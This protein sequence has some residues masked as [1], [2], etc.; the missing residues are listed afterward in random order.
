MPP[1]RKAA[2][3]SRKSPTPKPSCFVIS[4]I[5]DDGSPERRRADQVLRHLI[6]PAA[7]RAGYAKP[8][9]ADQISAPGIITQQVIQAVADAD[10]VIADLTEHNP[11]VFYELAIRHG[12][13]SPL[14][15]LLESSERLPFDIAQMRTIKFDIHDLDSVEQAREQLVAQINDLKTS[16]APIVTPISVTRDIK[17]MWESEDPTTHVLADVLAAISSLRADVQTQRPGYIGLAPAPRLG[18]EMPYRIGGS[19]GSAI[20]PLLKEPVAFG[21]GSPFFV[22]PAGSFS[23]ASGIDQ[24]PVAEEPRSRKSPPKRAQRRTRPKPPKDAPAD[25]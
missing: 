4:P 18:E 20:A 22:N 6:E 8:Q 23:Y 13:Q 9:R 17:A 7:R 16:D 11:N 14:V 15:Q 12:L 25:K 19:I 10:L 21:V 24:D 2:S 5:G 1:V 3:P